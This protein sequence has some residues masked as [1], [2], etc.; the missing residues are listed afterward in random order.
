MQKKGV[1]IVSIGNFSDAQPNT[2]GY[3]KPMLVTQ[4]RGFAGG[5]S[6]PP[7]PQAMFQPQSPDANS[8]VGENM[9][10]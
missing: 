9:N 6:L 4:I 8:V 7:T 3:V 1:E 5:S 2:N 10:G